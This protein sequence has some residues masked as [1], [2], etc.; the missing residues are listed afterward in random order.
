MGSFAELVAKTYMGRALLPQP[1]S[2]CMPLE[3]PPILHWTVHQSKS[4]L[5]QCA[6]AP[7]PLN[8]TVIENCNPFPQ[9]QKGALCNEI[10]R[11]QPFGVWNNCL[12]GTSAMA[13]Q[14]Q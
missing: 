10:Q 3:P 8:V 9:A 7:V 1:I 13:P 5:S 2:V 4:F 12:S 14:C 6:A 11:Q